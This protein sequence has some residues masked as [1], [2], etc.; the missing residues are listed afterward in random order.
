MSTPPTR[1]S[2]SWPQGITRPE[3]SEVVQVM[4]TEEMARRFEV[5]CLGRG[6]TVGHTYLAGPMKFSEDDLPT[7]MIG[8]G[9]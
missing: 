7:Y 5:R 3:P 8:T 2:E 1:R 9:E 4:M 6:N